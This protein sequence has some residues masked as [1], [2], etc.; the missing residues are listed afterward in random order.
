MGVDK[1]ELFKSPSPSPSHRGR[2]TDGRA[3]G[4]R[5]ITII[6]SEVP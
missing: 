4:I 3:C 5:I 1:G 6:V 2:G